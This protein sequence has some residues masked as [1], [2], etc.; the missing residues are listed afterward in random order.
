MELLKDVKVSVECS[1]CRIP[2]WQT[3][4]LDGVASVP[5]LT[6]EDVRGRGNNNGG[7]GKRERNKE[8]VVQESD[9]S[10]GPK[11]GGW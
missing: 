1:L 3:Q 5:R 6:E 11:K 2:V 10:K 8:Y 7:E 9:W 4:S